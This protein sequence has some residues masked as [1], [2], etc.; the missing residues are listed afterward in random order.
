MRAERL[1]FTVTGMDCGACAAKVQR[2]VERLPG[3]LRAEVA[4]M[5][6][7]LRL[8]LAPGGAGGEQIEAAIRAIG[9]GITPLPQMAPPAPAHQAGCCG[10]H[11]H[12]QGHDHG[13]A[14]DHDHD[15]DHGHAA[16][17]MTHAPAMPAPAVP[18]PAAP[19]WWQTARGRFLIGT[20]AL[21]GIAW[22]AKFALPAAVAHWVFV[23]ACLLGTL[24]VA[25][26]A[27]ALMRAGVLFTIEGLMTLAAAG[28]LIIGA[29]E[30]A[31][32][33]VFLF[34]VGEMLEALAAARAR[35]GIRALSALL[36]ETALLVHGD[37]THAVPTGKP[38]SGPDCPP[39]PRRPSAL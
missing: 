20:G 34:A 9:F 38:S 5:S 30:E 26:R 14:H 2:A 13:H 11:V 1:E 23:L 39:A 21:L 8:E 37:H 35:R 3:V 32:V 12:D 22:M 19:R 29:A 18:A 7:R 31:A 24:P 4:L 15:H 33:V 10:G 27:F 25:R 6:E 17:A 36:P 16:A 28:A